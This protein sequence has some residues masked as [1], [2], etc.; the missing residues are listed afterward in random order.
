MRES[1]LRTADNSLVVLL[2][3]MFGLALV[4]MAWVMAYRADRSIDPRLELSD[5]NARV[6]ELAGP[7]AIDCGWLPRYVDASDATGCVESA[8]R[9]GRPFKV[10][11]EHSFARDLGM[12]WH[13]HG[14]VRN[15]KGRQYLVS[16]M[17]RGVTG[18]DAF[19]SVRLCPRLQSRLD[20][21][22]PGPTC[23]YVVSGQRYAYPTFWYL[24]P[25]DRR[26]RAAARR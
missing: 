16:F 3:T 20:D 14:F 24:G 17:P 12:E 23:V 7:D 5:A 18:P 6:Q 19:L 10:M 13:W 9:S 26:A 15:A 21:G 2:A 22:A 1:T 11:R 4:G 8:I 25:P